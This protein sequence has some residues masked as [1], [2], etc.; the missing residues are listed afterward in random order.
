MR[1]RAR[2]TRGHPAAEGRGNRRRRGP[3]PARR[4]PQLRMQSRFTAPAP[5]PRWAARDLGPRRSERR[6]CSRGPSGGSGTKAIVCRGAPP[7]RSWGGATDRLRLVTGDRRRNREPPNGTR[8]CRLAECCFW[9]HRLPQRRRCHLRLP[10]V[11]VRRGDLAESPP[12]VRAVN[13]SLR[14]GQTLA[15]NTRSPLSPAQHRSDPFHQPPVDHRTAA[16]IRV[17]S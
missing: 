10:I 11:S 14:E 5:R 7:A 4:M 1:V 9:L 2:R 17:G 6:Q 16:W 15:R 12:A 13:G 8:A 3:R